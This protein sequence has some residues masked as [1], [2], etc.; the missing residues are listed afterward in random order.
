MSRNNINKTIAILCSAMTFATA[1]SVVAPISGL[2]IFNQ[3]DVA[4]QNKSTNKVIG[5]IREEHKTEDISK[6]N[7]KNY[8]TGYLT[9]NIDIRLTPDQNSDVLEIYDFNQKIRY[10]KYDKEW[11]E[12]KY[13]DTVA[14]I[15]NDYI[16]NEKCNYTKYDIPKNRGFKSYMSYT[17]IK[18]K[19][20]K[21]YKLQQQCYTGEY[22]IRMI[23]GRYCIAIGTYFKA[24]IG[25]Y[26]DLILENGTKIPCIVGDIK[27]DVHTKSDNITTKSN[28]CVSEF[29]IDLK[30]LDKR[31]KKS[32]NM[33]SICEEWDSPVESFYIYDN[34][35]EE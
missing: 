18:N 14:Y 5:K 26:V 12:I 31:A 1:T 27:A 8:H 9:S 16:S 2:T 20:S 22:G 10:A 34:K 7:I 19:E 13:K 30:K 17:A 11:S 32:G 3:T 6:K 25:D 33:S 21:Q 29:I 23:K 35:V 24:N 4:A 28:G 15:H